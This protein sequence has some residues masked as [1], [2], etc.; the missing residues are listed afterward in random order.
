MMW[1]TRSSNELYVWRM[2]RGERVLVYKKWYGTT[3]PSRLFNTQLP[4]RVIK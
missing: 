2:E 3:Q 1:S 4:D